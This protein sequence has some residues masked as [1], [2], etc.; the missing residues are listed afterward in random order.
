MDQAQNLRNIV[1]KHIESENRQGNARVIT[2]TSG[3]GG[4]GKTS[5]SLNLAI[6][7]KKMG[8]EVIIFDADFGLANIEVMIGAIPKYNLSDMIY[9]GK[10]LKDILMTGPMGIKYISGGSG[11]N[12]FENLSKDQMIYLLHEFHQ[13][14][15]MADIIIIDTGAGI[16]HTVMEF[17]ASSR[18]V[19]LVTTPEPTSITDAYSLLKALNRH[20]AFDREN[21]LVKL[22]VNKA[23]GYEDGKNLYDKLN[24]VVS[25]F[26]QMK[27]E[28]TGVVPEDKSMVKS[29]IMQSPASISFPESKAAYSFLQIAEILTDKRSEYTDYKSGLSYIFAKY[30]RMRRG[31]RKCYPEQ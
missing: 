30:F 12:Q 26:L 1:K 21:A 10:S 20:E 9:R 15:T 2:V 3:K 17:V 29:I 8:K 16:S 6:Q 23:D 28:F 19:L 31:N 4:V 24:T 5:V 7:F 14:E 27:L 13:L 22:V 18:E 25:R 11:V